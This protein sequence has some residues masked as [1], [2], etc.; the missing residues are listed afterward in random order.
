MKWMIAALLLAGACGSRGSDCKTVAEC[1]A[2]F[3]TCGADGGVWPADLGP[4]GTGSGAQPAICA[5]YVSCAT[6]VEPGGASAILAAYGPSGSCWNSGSQV[7]GTCTTACQKGIEGLHASDPADCPLCATSADCSGATPVCDSA[8]GQCV[9]CMQNGDCPSAT[10][11]CKS[12]KCVAGCVTSAQCG[13]GVCD[14]SSNQCVE[15]V[16]DN[17]CASST[18]GKSCDGFTHSCGCGLFGGCDA[19]QLCEDSV[20]CTPDCGTK[21]CGAPSGCGSALTDYCG[22]CAGGVCDQFN[23]CYSNNKVCTPGVGACFDTEACVYD[24]DS[25]GY[26]C[27]TDTV[28]IIG[29][30]C[31]QSSDCDFEA[32]DLRAQQFECYLGKCRPYCLGDND[33]AM[34]THCVAW[35]SEPIS[36]TW[37]GVCVAP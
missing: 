5:T 3:G 37:P 18:R 23:V 21:E 27:A 34:G 29:E 15:C 19:G 2:R 14:P 31:G 35:A 24:R 16:G 25:S 36:M 28:H 6:V 4:S 12:E 20:C 30:A 13:N 22:S 7:A 33:C 11:V 32:S 1:C 26:K 17:D 8:E 10:P 9:A